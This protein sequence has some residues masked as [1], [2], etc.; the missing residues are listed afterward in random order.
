MPD[1]LSDEGHDLAH[2][3]SLRLRRVLVGLAMQCGGMAVTGCAY[4]LGIVAGP[5]TLVYFALLLIMN[6]CWVGLVLT[7]INLRFPDPSMTGEQIALSVFP[8]VYIMYYIEEPQARMIFLLFASIAMMF[9]VFRFGLRGMATLGIWILA[10]YLLLLVALAAWAPD[11]VNL[12]VEIL[13][14]FAYGVSLSLVAYMGTLISQLRQSLVKRNG[15]LRKAMDKLHVLATRD[16]LT[17]LANRHTVM[18]RLNHEARSTATQTTLCVCMLDV[19][20]FKRINDT[21]GHQ[22]GDLVLQRVA[23]ALQNSLR[24]GD[25]V[26]R[27]GGEEFML[28]LLQSDC[29]GAIRAANRI[30]E[31]I[32]A[33]IIEELPPGEFVTV[34]IG[35][36]AR[37]EGEAVD[38]TIKRADDALY[39]AKNQGRNLVTLADCPAYESS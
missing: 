5:P 3:Q 27:F 31:T 26:G 2:A 15:Q 10:S 34:S 21:Y 4:L 30:R 14:V 13:V 11:R 8:A 20:H 12:R 18:E 29:E 9:G 7:N 17:G 36:A 35:V 37:A 23:S 25:F 22:T 32:A 19:D 28:I 33:E 16:S 6:A 39:A 38:K 1:A 24:D